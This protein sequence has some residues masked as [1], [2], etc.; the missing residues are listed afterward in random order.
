MTGVKRL[1]EVIGCLD[2][3]EGP[4]AK[5]AN[6]LG[7]AP[8]VEMG[9]K[10]EVLGEALGVLPFGMTAILGDGATKHVGEF[11]TGVA[12]VTGTKAVPCS[13]GPITPAARPVG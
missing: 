8:Q 4:G 9:G 13:A 11:V 2:G 6:D 10:R 7:I 1:D 3:K 12:N 5:I